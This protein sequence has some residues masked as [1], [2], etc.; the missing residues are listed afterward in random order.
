MIKNNV[1]I[2]LL[3]LKNIL[4]FACNELITVKKILPDV[5]CF[6]S[7]KVWY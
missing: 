5:D 3:D 2:K 1:T 7:E 4:Q 6:S